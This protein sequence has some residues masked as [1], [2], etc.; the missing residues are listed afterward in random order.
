MKRGT[1]KKVLFR[2]LLNYI[3]GYV[4][5]KV[6]GYFVER[7][8][9]I[10]ISKKILLWNIKRK[11]ST[12]L[13]ANI[14]ISDYKKLKSINRK[15][16]TQIKIQSKKG[17]PFLLHKYRKRKIFGI[18]LGG[19]ILSLIILSNFIW[20]IDIIGNE[21][22]SKQEIINSLNEQ[23]LKIGINK[24]KIDTN[25]IINRIRLQRNDIAW[26]GIKIN[27]TN[28]IIE[29]K[30]TK[31]AP[32]IINE[33]EYCNIVSNKT[34]MITKIDVQNGTAVVKEGDIVKQNDILVM[35]NIDGKYTGT[36]YVHAKADI[37]AKIWYS[38]KEKV[39]F[40]QEIQV[41]TGGVEEKYSININNFKINL[42]KKPS[43]F[44]NY[45][46]INENKKIVIFKN[47]YL[48]LE[49]IKTTNYEYRIEEI[50]Y[51]EQ[52]LIEKTKKRL[53]QEIE[54]QIEQKE[55][56]VN[57]QTNIYPNEQFIEVEVIYEVIEHMGNKQKIVF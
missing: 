27:G 45:D 3:T 46:T 57:V 10:C 6:E 1:R 21:S 17:L 26:I 25:S 39:F 23:G 13:Y 36:R 18:F 11:K 55:N 33:Q 32:E 44:E 15:T 41:P 34:G 20:N 2:I 29:I 48:P 5:I 53:K 49:L 52:D 28:A 7:F 54:A 38:K 14:G 19:V 47:F 40:T 35:G 37:E 43:K 31:K 8:L 42:Y 22:I 24:N 16:K 12:T 30:E 4:N 9:N 50:T 51:T 56:I